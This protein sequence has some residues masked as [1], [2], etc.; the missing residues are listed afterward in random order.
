MICEKEIE[1]A[2][3]VLA[4]HGVPKDRAG[5]VSNGIEIYAIRMLRQHDCDVAE[6]ENLRNVIR[7]CIHWF[8]IQEEYVP[9]STFK[10]ITELCER[11]LPTSPP[12]PSP[13]P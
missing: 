6:I 4:I 5:T 1:N 8:K 11:A 7:K 9:G 2:F 12:T 13:Q 10:H 3:S